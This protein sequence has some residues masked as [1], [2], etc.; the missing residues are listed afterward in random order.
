ME[1]KGCTYHALGIAQGGQNA[2]GRQEENRKHL[3]PAILLTPYVSN[4]QCRHATAAAQDDV[5][6]HRYIVAKG[7]VV[8]HGNAEE[9]HDLDQPSVDRN[10]VRLQER[11]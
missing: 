2:P 5:Y 4:H 6:G 10:L 8:E 11:R 1:W 3:K 7:I 9:Q